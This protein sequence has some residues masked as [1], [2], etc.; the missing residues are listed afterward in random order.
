M[1]YLMGGFPTLE[2]SRVV[3][4]AYVAG[5]ADLVELGVPFADALADGP[6]IPA[7]GVDAL[8]AGATVDA[9]LKLGAELAAA[10]PVVLMCYTNVVLAHGPDAF[11]E[12]LAGAGE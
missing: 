10:V 2:A 3:A 6:V 9:V 8:R 5:G 12:R 7:A 4:E 1:P 11:A